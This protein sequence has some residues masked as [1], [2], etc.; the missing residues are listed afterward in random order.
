MRYII[1][2]IAILVTSC[3]VNR[4][5]YNLDLTLTNGKVITR[6]YKLPKDVT[7]SIKGKDCLIY[8]KKDSTCYCLVTNVIKFKRNE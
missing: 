3:G 7:L 5:V 2:I 6:H 4:D 1:I 8:K